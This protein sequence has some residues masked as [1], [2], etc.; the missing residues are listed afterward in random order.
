MNKVSHQSE[1]T[2]TATSWLD[3]Q[4]IH[5]YLKNKYKNHEN[6]LVIPTTNPNSFEE[7]YMGTYAQISQDQRDILTDMIIPFHMEP[8]KHF[9]LLHVKFIGDEKKPVIYW[10]DSMGDAMPEKVKNIV[11]EVFQQHDKVIHE[12]AAGCQQT[13]GYDCGVYVT[14]NAD[15]L[16]NN[17]DAEDIIENNNEFNT[18]SRAQSVELRQEIV[19]IANEDL[20]NQYVYVGAHVAEKV[21]QNQWDQNKFLNTISQDLVAF[22]ATIQNNENAFT[23]FDKAFDI[24]AAAYQKAAASQTKNRYAFFNEYN[25]LKAKFGQHHSTAPAKSCAAEAEPVLDPIKVV[26]YNVFKQP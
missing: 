5:A 3:A 15:T 24:A 18:M 19:G 4:L 20:V 13:N 8:S 25:S 2:V 14:L 16:V 7:F 23:T 10:L 6:I 21:D 17:T 12:R 1:L 26:N 22:G 9:T 11:D